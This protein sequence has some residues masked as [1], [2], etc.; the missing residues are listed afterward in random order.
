[1]TGVSD[2]RGMKHWGAPSIERFLLDGWDATKPKLQAAGFVSYQPLAI[3]PF[4]ADAKHRGLI[5]GDLLV[6]RLPVTRG[7]ASS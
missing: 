7:Q 2:P 1:F 6:N 3:R 5:R 4:C